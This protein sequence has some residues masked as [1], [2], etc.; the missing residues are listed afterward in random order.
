[1]KRKVKV[2]TKQESITSFSFPHQ[3]SLGLKHVHLPEV[4]SPASIPTE[5]QRLAEIRH[6]KTQDLD[7]KRYET[8]P[9]DTQAEQGHTGDIFWL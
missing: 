4:W 6:S 2:S 7:R 1:M 3:V 8:R 9:Q 5:P